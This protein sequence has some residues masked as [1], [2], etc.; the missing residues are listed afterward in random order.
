M[1]TY[2]TVITQVCW[3][4]QMKNCRY[5]GW[6]K[7]PQPFFIYSATCCDSQKS[8]NTSHSSP[9]FNELVR[10]FF[11][12]FIFLQLLAF[13]FFSFWELPLRI[14][15]FLL[16]K[17]IL[18]FPKRLCNW[19]KNWNFSHDV[20]LVWCAFVNFHFYKWLP[21]LFT[22]QHYIFTQIHMYIRFSI[23][24]KLFFPTYRLNLYIC[25]MSMNEWMKNE[26]KKNVD[27]NEENC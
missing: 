22:I 20:L 24:K 7:F 17:K 16:P 9:C 10:N 21:Q 26:K 11:S 6:K 23:P 15:Y 1:V 13:L 5:S 3:R 27:G 25:I 8:K 14:S 4:C 18:P 19:N 12:P 2:S